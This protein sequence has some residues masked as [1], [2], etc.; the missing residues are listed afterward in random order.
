MSRRYKIGINPQYDN[1]FDQLKSSSLVLNPRA[2]MVN[3]ITLEVSF[4]GAS[5]I[6]ADWEGKLPVVTAALEGVAQEFENLKAR[7]RRSGRPVPQEEPPALLEKRLRAEALVDITGDEIAAL[8][9]LA[10]KQATAEATRKP[11][12]ALRHGPRGTALG[13][14]IREIDGQVVVEREGELY[15]SCPE[16][17]YDGLALPTYH[18]AVVLPFLRALRQERK[19]AGRSPGGAAS[20]FWPP[21][22]EA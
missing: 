1:H 8:R 19:R 18:S 10:E 3:E 11:D 20:Q 17:I 5:R 13:D 21:R 22:P 12:V 6:L 16:S 15:I 9:R 2:S 7:A 14:P 4:G